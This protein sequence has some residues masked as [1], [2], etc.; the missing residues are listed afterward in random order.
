M[1][2]S[3]SAVFLVEVVGELTA[4][5]IGKVLYLADLFGR[6][7]DYLEHR[8]K[9]VRLVVLSRECTA[10]LLDFARR[11]RPRRLAARRSRRRS[12]GRF[13]S[14]RPDAGGVARNR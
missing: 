4:A 7:P 9:R 3:D 8:G 13:Q 5:K 10:S 2:Y 12:T 11:R 14:R 6:D 1:A